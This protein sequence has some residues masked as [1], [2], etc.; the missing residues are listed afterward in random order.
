MN[1]PQKVRNE[2]KKTCAFFGS[3]P[4]AVFK[5]AFLF[6]GDRVFVKEPVDV[7]V[8]TIL[9]KVDVR[10]EESNAV[11][12]DVSCILLFPSNSLSHSLILRYKSRARGDN[13]SQV[14]GLV[15][16]SDTPPGLTPNI[17]SPN[18]WKRRMG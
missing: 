13:C 2:I 14:F 8:S 7:N 10:D 9:E 6:C 17:T 3:S 15:R 5:A 12:V 16:S 18:V 4:V 11:E 1:L